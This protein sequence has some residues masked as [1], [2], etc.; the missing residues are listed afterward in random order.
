MMFLECPLDCEEIQLVHPTKDQS[1][2]FIRKT[3]AEADTWIIWPRDA[4]KWLI[5][6]TPML[7]KIEVLRRRGWQ[8]MRWLDCVTNSMDMILS[9]LLELVLDREAWHAAVLGSQRVGLN[10]LAENELRHPGKLEFHRSVIWFSPGLCKELETNDERTSKSRHILVELFF[11]P[12][13]TS[14][15]PEMCSLIAQQLHAFPGCLSFLFRNKRTHTCARVLSEASAILCSSL[16]GFRVLADSDGCDSWP[17]QSDPAEKYS[18]SFHSDSRW[19]WIS[20]SAGFDSWVIG[21]PW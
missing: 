9:N 15:L 5:G 8:R 2:I 18:S 10:W 12:L 20:T 4:K 13:R 1:L 11:F 7:G 17:L 3:D 14:L 21:I 19:F 16:D 6:K